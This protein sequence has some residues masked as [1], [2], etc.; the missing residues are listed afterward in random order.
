MASSGIGGQ[1]V[2]EGVMMKNQER[3]AVAVRKPD[4]SIIIETKEYKS[5]CKNKAGCNHSRPKIFIPLRTEEASPRPV[6]SH[7]VSFQHRFA[8]PPPKYPGS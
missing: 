2:M 3:Y 7:S 4:Q 1:A 6:S 8:A 5:I